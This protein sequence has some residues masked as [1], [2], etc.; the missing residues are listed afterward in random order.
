LLPPRLATLPSPTSVDP[1]HPATVM[2]DSTSRTTQKSIID[3]T[4]KR[5]QKSV[6]D[7]TSGPI[8]NSQEDK[9]S[10]MTQNSIVDSTSGKSGQHLVG[11]MVDSRCDIKASS[12]A[13]VPQK[14]MM[15]PP[16]SF[17]V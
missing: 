11:R 16:R 12:A 6:V 14:R 8:Q 5:I 13:A 1:A 9:A 7:S 4:S 10:K 2:V 15:T 3:I 17:H